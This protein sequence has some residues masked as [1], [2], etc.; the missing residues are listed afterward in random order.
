MVLHLTSTS[1]DVASGRIKYSIART[2]RYIHS[3]KNMDM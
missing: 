1:H 2:A 3:L